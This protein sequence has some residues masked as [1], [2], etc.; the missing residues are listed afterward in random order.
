MRNK[1]RRQHLTKQEPY[2]HLPPTT[3]TMKIRRTRH[4]RHCWRNRDDVLLHMD[5][6][7]QDDQLE[8]TYCSSVPIRDV[9]LRT[10]RKQWTIGRGGERGSG[11]SVLMAR[12]DDDEYEECSKIKVQ[13]FNN[14]TFIYCAYGTSTTI[15]LSFFVAIGINAL[16]SSLVSELHIQL[17]L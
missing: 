1:S 9:T 17:G 10:C 3:K 8:L 5:D 4:A 2:G 7:R 11:I 6:Q 14:L 16:V 12:H 15:L 13:T